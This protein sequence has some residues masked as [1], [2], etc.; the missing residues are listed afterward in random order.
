MSNF[1]AR[2]NVRK[3]LKLS[4]MDGAVYSA[5]MGLTQ[6]Y[7]TPFALALKATSE[8]IGLLSSIP[9]FTTAFSQLAA[10][11]L[12]EKT[13]SRKRMILPIV[14]VHAIVWLLVFLMP[15]FFRSS[16]IWWLI[17]L[18]TVSTVAGAIVLPAWG[19]MMADLVH[20]DVRG[21]YFSFRNRI[22]TFTTL[23]FS[24]IAG[25]LLQLFTGN[26]FAGFAIIFGGATLFR[27][28][29]LYFLSRMYEPPLAQQKSNDAGLFHMIANLGSSNIG[30]FTI[31]IGLISCAVMISGPFFSV[32]ML[33]DLKLDYVTYTLIVSSS[34]I[35]TIIAL[36]FWGRRADRAGNLRIIRLTAW[37]LPVVPLLW[38]VSV[39]PW[40][41]VAANMFSGFAWSGFDL[42]SSNFVYDTSD[43]ASRTRQLAV[44]NCIA[45][46][47]A[48]LGALASGYIAP[49]LPA[50]LGYQLRTLFVVS[51]ALRAIIILLVLRYIS[52][53][54]HVPKI[55]TFSLLMGRAS[56]NRGSQNHL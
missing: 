24:L 46:V 43:P 6:S 25:A 19:S 4:V 11:Q 27:S 13:G 1:K 48:S 28:L 40:Y 29:S 20:E 15:Y 55:G 7:I 30:R 53:V 8:Q 26:V 16:G 9:N 52:E 45:S 56:H 49:H 33:R 54:R 47:T 2:L 18:F 34:T 17:G 50:M 42:S 44:F 41:L 23:I 21:R 14:F 32:Y 51:G 22:M 39:N 5:M 10:P 31:F 12:V 37:L 38:L 35:G 3:S 36:P